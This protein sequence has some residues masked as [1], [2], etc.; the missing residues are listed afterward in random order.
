VIAGQGLHTGAPA[1][2]RLA[3]RD[4]P[5]AFVRDGET[6][7]LS[8]LRVAS[9]TR[10]TTLARADG[11]F[12]VATVEHLFAALAAYGARRGVAI[13]LEGDST[14]LASGG[15]HALTGT[16][17]PLADGG[18]RAFADAL[19]A[20]EVPSSPPELVV[21]RSATIPIGAASYV[22]VPGDGVVV[23]VHV[24]FDDARLAHDARW[25]G[26]AEDFRTRIAPA[27]TFGFAHEVDELAARGLASHVAPESV[28]VVCEDRI[29]SAGRPFEADEPAR[30]KLLDLMGDLFVHGGPPRGSIVA[31]R[32]GHAATHEAIGRALAAGVLAR[33]C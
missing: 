23:D 3:R 7:L 1:S 30:H 27:R 8:E 20:L 10:S 14:R 13:A 5:T 28:V 26:D 31:R 22:F 18:A 16:E 4:G 11:G 15:A 32:P 9:T 29:L 17:I 19:R 24:D 21:V 2:I 33:S 12:A 25:D 6:V